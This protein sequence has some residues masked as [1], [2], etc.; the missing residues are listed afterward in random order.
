VHCSPLVTGSAN[1]KVR[2]KQTD[3]FHG[4]NQNTNIFYVMVCDFFE[5]QAIRDHWIVPLGVFGIVNVGTFQ[6]F[7]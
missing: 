1:A 2:D 7:N 5:M 3:F 4:R 6:V